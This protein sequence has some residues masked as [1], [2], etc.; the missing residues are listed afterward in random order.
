MAASVCM[1]PTRPRCS[2]LMT[3][4]AAQQRDPPLQFA[5]WSV[6]EQQELAAAVTLLQGSRKDDA[7][8]AG[9]ERIDTHMNRLDLV[10]CFFGGA[11]R[12]QRGNAPRS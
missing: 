6:D 5:R 11:S 1:P 2:P 8:A 4:G 9:L 3:Q 10:A 7:V 12:C